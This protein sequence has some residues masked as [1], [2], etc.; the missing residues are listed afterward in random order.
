MSAGVIRVGISGWT[1]GPW[2]GVFYPKG[3]R[4]EEELGYAASPRPAHLAR[5]NG[6]YALV[7]RTREDGA[8]PRCAR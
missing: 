6:A 8:G 2:R 7:S 5:D 3:L 4:R 1:Y